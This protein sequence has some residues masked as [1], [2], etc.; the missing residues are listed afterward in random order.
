[1]MRLLGILLASILALAP[2][3]AG[4]QGVSTQRIPGKRISSLAAHELTS[5]SLDPD[6]DLV[7]ASMVP[8]QVVEGGRVDLHAGTPVGNTSFI[9][10]PVEIDVDGRTQRTVMV[11]YR[12]Q[13]YVQTAVASHD[14]VPG[15][16]LAPEDLTI[17]RVAYTGQASNGIDALVGRKVLF[18]ALKGSPITIQETAVNQIVQAGSTVVFIVR[19]SG[20]A[21]TADAVARTSGGLGDEVFVYNPVTRKALSGTVTGPGTVELDISGGD[22]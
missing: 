21:V 20:V 11:G 15:T 4:A 7:Q 13:Q 16:V 17:G 12:V 6:Q 10:V 3:A 8:D 9:N 5:V 1:M 14:L 18:T 19:D 22:Q 2:L